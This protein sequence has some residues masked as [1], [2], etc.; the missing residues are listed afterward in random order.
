[1]MTGSSQEVRNLKY[2]FLLISVKYLK[3]F[4]IKINNRLILSKQ[5]L[6]K[7]MDY[8]ITSANKNF[9]FLWQTHIRIDSKF[10]IKR[11]LV[12]CR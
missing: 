10:T 9:K 1:M 12:K 8:K 3:I 4:K 5:T 6:I 2:I 7:I 11:N